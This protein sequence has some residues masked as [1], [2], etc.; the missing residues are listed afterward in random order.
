MEDLRHDCNF[1]LEF[2]E[3]VVIEILHDE[4]LNSNVFATQFTAVHITER[5]ASCFSLIKK[6][7]LDVVVYGRK[8]NNKKTTKHAANCC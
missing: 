3:C 4:L 5:S 6:L 2:C 8:K 1:F 7:Q